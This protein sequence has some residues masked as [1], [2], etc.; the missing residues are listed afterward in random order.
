[1]MPA[2]DST[3]DAPYAICDL[4]SRMARTLEMVFMRKQ[5]IVH[6]NDKVHAVSGI[7]ASANKYG[8]SASRA[9][10]QT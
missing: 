2:R 1:V 3:D 7:L 6:N 8:T 9:R 4:H 5:Q 10:R